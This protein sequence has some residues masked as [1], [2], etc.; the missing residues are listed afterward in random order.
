M[1][2][3]AQAAVSF[4][5][6]PRRLVAAI[7]RPGAIGIVAPGYGTEKVSYGLAAPGFTFHKLLRLPIHRLE[8]QG[9]FWQ[10]TP[11]LLDHPVELVHTFNEL[12][13]GVRPFVVSFENE[14]PRYL[15]SPP[16]W[17]C[18]LGYSLLA[19]DRCRAIL[20][21]SE[22]AA[23]G[24]RSRLEARDLA[25]VA[26]KVT[27]F[28]GSVLPPATD[29]SANESRDPNGPLRVLFVG[30]DPL[31]KGLSPTLDALE[32][33][34]RQGARVEATIV[35]DFNPYSYIGTWTP[36]DTAATR[37]RLHGLAG[38]RHIERVSNPEIHRLMRSHDVL[39]FPTLDES[40]G[41]VAIEAAMAGMAVVTTDVF[42]LPELVIDGATGVLISL[43]KNE[44]GRWKGLWL[45]GSEFQ[46][47]LDAAFAHIRSELSSS[48]IGFAS[49]RASALRMGAAA[50]SHIG[51][52]YGF[53]AA[54]QQLAKIYCSALGR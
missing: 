9:T 35:C 24:L 30:R 25:G 14:M 6:V 7:G 44:A 8:R 5:A 15:G 11:I 18:D 51:A 27:V 38:I 47:E 53:A 46:T 12:P 21:L 31:R 28:R 2:G 29:E 36:A 17:Q 22:A 49:D 20:A 19:S 10:H 54:R 48:L 45:Q 33:C 16:A 52:L 40:L 32:D 50:R 3:S 26:R 42:A 13:L 43:N 41:W 23:A 1:T 34:I 4:A 37:V 39:L